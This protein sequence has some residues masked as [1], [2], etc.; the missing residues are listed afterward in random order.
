MN[1]AGSWSP[2]ANNTYD[3]GG[4]G[5]SWNNAWI[6]NI[7]IS[8]FETVSFST[9]S[10]NY[11]VAATD[12]IVQFT[13]G[14][15]CTMPTSTGNAGR[16]VYIKNTSSGNITLSGMASG[17]TTLMSIAGT[18]GASGAFYSD[19]AGAGWRWMSYGE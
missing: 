9:H 12:V 6:K 17:E 4:S 1:V 5:N 8:G 3:L 14:A 19:G 13:A 11:T 16:V 2:T 15:T 7:T 18:S 10:G